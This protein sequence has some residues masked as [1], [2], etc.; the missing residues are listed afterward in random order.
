MP[1]V[2]SIVELQEEMKCYI[3]FSDEDVFDGIALPEETPITAPKEATTKSAPP[4]P[5]NPP[6]K[7][8]TMDSTIE[9]GVEKRSLNKVP[10]WEK[11][12]HP[13]RPIVA[14]WQT[15][16]LSR[17]LRWRPCSRSLGE[18]LVWIPLPEELKVSTTQSE[19]P[20]PTKELEVAWWV[21]P[22]PGFASVTVC[23]Q[24]DQPPEEVP[25]PDSLRMAVLSGPAVATM[26]TSHI[27]KD[28]V[29]GVTYM[30]TVTTSVGQVT[31]SGPGQEA[32]AQGPTIQNITDLV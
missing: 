22:P 18:G 23:L 28:E 11:V 8:A 10:G 5:A 4:T 16:P 13:S 17:G 12:L 30:E 2:G 19:P 29:I 6:V 3:S 26:S 24:R 20:S 32:S 21:I 25:D 31:L 14:T 9:P 27:I 7:E 15:S 1:L